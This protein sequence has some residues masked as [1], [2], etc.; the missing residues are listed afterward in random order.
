LWA[1]IS[2][3]V[4]TFND[5]DLGDASPVGPC[6]WGRCRSDFE[7]ERDIDGEMPVQCEACSARKE[8]R[9]MRTNFWKPYALVMTGAFALCIGNSISVADAA[10]EPHL[11]GALKQL[12]TAMGQL[13]KAT[14]SHGGHRMQAIDL[15]RQAIAQTRLAM[16]T[17]DAEKNK[18]KKPPPP[19]IP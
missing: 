7:R 16:A 10:G 8:K 18:G 5:S 15:T 9:R 3:T 6:R 12:E 13:Q 17:P 19:V 2:R 4:S 11:N 14:G 1:G